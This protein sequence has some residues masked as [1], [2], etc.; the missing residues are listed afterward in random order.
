MFFKSFVANYSDIAAKLHS[1]THEDFNWD[2]RTWTED[3]VKAFEQM[4]QALITAVALFFPDYALP[5]ILRVDASDV[6]VGAVLCQV[7]T[8][9][10]GTER[11]EKKK[12]HN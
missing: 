7:R 5:W 4:K 10:D 12:D 1:M 2:K 3:Y 9:E 11:F 8:A 6:A